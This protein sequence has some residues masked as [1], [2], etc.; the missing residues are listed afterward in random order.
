[1]IYFAKVNKIII[2]FAPFK[3]MKKKLTLVPKLVQMKSPLSYL[4]SV[5]PVLWFTV[6]QDLCSAQ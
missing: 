1:M 2:L 4:Y 6:L 3:K 5:L